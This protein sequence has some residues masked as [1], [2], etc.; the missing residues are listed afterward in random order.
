MKIL[1]GEKRFYVL[2]DNG[3]EI[4][5]VTY[6]QAGENILIIDHTYVNPDYRGQGIA[7][8]LV[9]H[10]V[11]LAREINKVIMPLCPFAAQEFKRKAEYSDVLKK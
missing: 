2:N 5:E 10:V 7:E 11:D 4:G 3:D 6:Q 1:A 9:K 8:D